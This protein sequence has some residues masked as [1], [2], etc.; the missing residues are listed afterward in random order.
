MLCAS[1]LR[2]CMRA[3]TDRFV[4]LEPPEDD[5]GWAKVLPLAADYDANEEAGFVPST[6]I[7]AVPADGVMLADFRGETEGE[8]DEAVMDE[9]VWLVCPSKPAVDG[10]C[11]V[12][13][14]RCRRGNVPESFV[15][16]RLIDPE[17]YVPAGEELAVAAE[18]VPNWTVLR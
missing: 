3:R 12:I 13:T 1:R 6:F 5:S 14:S 4:L 15:E 11:D 7:E 8:M 2:G 10:W 9:L 16:W 17:T 18:E